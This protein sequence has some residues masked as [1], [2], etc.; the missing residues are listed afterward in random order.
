MD[1]IKKGA[2]RSRMGSGSGPKA[3]KTWKA[4]GPHTRHGPGTE[5]KGKGS[6][7]T[8]KAKKM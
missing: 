7:K 3:T 2:K 5:P 1:G 4:A 8:P 6:G